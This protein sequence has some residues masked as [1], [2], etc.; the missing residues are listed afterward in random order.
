MRD[1]PSAE[2]SSVSQTDTSFN[3]ECTQIALVPDGNDGA[4][5]TSAVPSRKDYFEAIEH[6]TI[7]GQ[8]FRVLLMTANNQIRYVLNEL[9]KYK[10]LQILNPYHIGIKT[11]EDLLYLVTIAG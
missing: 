10:F 1:R 4:S 8:A 5:I 6:Q 9:C 3:L 2:T 11:K 7:G